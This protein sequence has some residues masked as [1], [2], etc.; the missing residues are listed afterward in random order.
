M[1]D[2][3]MSGNYKEVMID[4]DSPYVKGRFFALAVKNLRPSVFIGQSVR[5][6]D[7][8]WISVPVYPLRSLVRAVTTR[9]G[10]QREEAT[11]KVLPVVS[12]PGLDVTP[13]KLHGLQ[14]ADTTLARAW[15]TAKNKTVLTAGKHSKTFCVVRG[16][17]RRKYS[18][19]LEIIPK[20]VYQRHSAPAS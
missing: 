3:S 4:L 2:E 19:K 10:Q 12:I 5:N 9:A 8:D 16:V 18:D 7:G 14:E 15:E 11:P 1:A 20:S 6:T 13:A 17:L